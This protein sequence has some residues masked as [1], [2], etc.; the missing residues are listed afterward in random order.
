MDEFVYIIRPVKNN[1]IDTMTE[2]ENQIMERHFQYL[3]EL[4]AEKKLI[5]AG[6]CLDGAFGIVIFLSESLDTAR[7]IM[8][9]DPSVLA[10]LMNAEVHP[11]R[12]S[13]HSFE[14]K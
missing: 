7:A 5:L 14:N 9:K 4:Q 2:E 1:F 12:V 11:Y 6:P 13:L 8:E 3:Q 10:G